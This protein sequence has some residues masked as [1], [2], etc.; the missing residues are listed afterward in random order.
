MLISARDLESTPLLRHDIILDT[1]SNETWLTGSDYSQSQFAGTHT[2]F[3]PLFIP[4]E[5]T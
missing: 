3:F 2:L 4:F 1:R 5:H